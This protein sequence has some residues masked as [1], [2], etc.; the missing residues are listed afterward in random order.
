[1]MLHTSN[2]R[3]ERLLHPREIVYTNPEFTRELASDLAGDCHT[4][5]ALKVGTNGGAGKHQT[6]LK[7]EMNNL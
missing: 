4:A 2:L 7:L 3:M 6:T 1:M 5:C